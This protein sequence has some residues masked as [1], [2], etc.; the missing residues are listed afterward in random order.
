VCACE[1][2]NTHD[3]FADDEAGND[4]MTRVQDKVKTYL[5]RQHLAIFVDALREQRH[6]L[7]VER[8]VGVDGQRNTLRQVVD[9]VHVYLL[10]R[11]LVKRLKATAQ[12]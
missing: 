12:I 6:S 2:E 11:A 9:A 8:V 1:S 3:N 7:F 4:E 5:H 10:E